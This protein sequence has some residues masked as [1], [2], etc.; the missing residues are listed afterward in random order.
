MI[1]IGGPAGIHPTYWYSWNWTGTTWQ[2]DTAIQKGLTD[3]DEV[4]IPTI[5]EMNDNWY[6]ISGDS[7]GLFHGF[8][9]TETLFDTN[10]T[11]IQSSNVLTVYANDSLGNMNS[12]TV[13]FYMD[14]Y[15]PTISSIT[16]NPTTCAT[17]PGSVVV[18]WHQTD[19]L[20]KLTSWCNYT[21]PTG[22][23][24]IKSVSA[25]NDSDASCSMYMLGLGDWSILVHVEDYA[26]NTAESA[27]QVR[28][29]LICGGQL[30][31]S[32][33]VDGGPIAP[34]TNITIFRLPNCTAGYTYD[35]LTG[36]CRILET[37]SNLSAYSAFE[38]GLFRPSLFQV[39]FNYSAGT[40]A[41]GNPIVAT[42][43]TY[44][45]SVFQAVI[46][47][48]VL[49]FVWYRRSRTK[50]FQQMDKF[51]LIAAAAFFA[52]SIYTAVP[53]E[54]WDSLNFLPQPFTLTTP[55]SVLGYNPP[56]TPIDAYLGGAYE[57]VKQQSIA[58]VIV[59]ALAAAIVLFIKH[60]NK[61]FKRILGE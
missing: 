28:V 32:G 6:M 27:G 11:A 44:L 30:P 17:N 31:V 37:P 3:I 58:L 7:S 38:F 23:S 36:R 22:T 45:L 60:E 10:F 47:G 51:M 25:G 20:N 39:S 48:S 4:P 56:Q 50:R 21:S 18:N 40:D 49:L 54:A 15:F 35:I 8:N 12:S 26:N 52:M 43:T 2:N 24:T 61:S 16:Q 5:F 13:N 53:T 42:H 46:I 19:N 29:S 14:T 55:A 57:A 41:A 9:L 34:P 33:G 1:S 59:I